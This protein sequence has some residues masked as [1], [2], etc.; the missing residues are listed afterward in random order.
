MCPILYNYLIYVKKK[1]IAI[2]SFILNCEALSSNALEA[3]VYN[4]V[5]YD[6]IVF[7]WRIGF[8]FNVF[9]PDEMALKAY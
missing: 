7:H 1:K 8:R 6:I 3:W 4:I 5:L 2:N 9:R